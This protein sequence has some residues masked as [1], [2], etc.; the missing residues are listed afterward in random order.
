MIAWVEAY[1]AQIFAGSLLVLLGIL[2][3]VLLVVAHRV[4]G[5]GRQLQQIT[6]QVQH[7]LQV[8]LETD[9]SGASEEPNE[10]AAQKSSEEEKSRL[11]SAVLQEIFP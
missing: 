8:V 6:E 1:H 3:M 11:I 7:Y 4:R 2:I 5:I 10:A 9:G